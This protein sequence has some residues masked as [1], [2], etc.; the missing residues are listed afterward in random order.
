MIRIDAL[1]PL[2]VAVDG[3]LAPRELLWRKNL[4]LLLYLARSPRG[5]RPRNG[6]AS[7]FW[8][9]KPESDARHSLNEAL[10][11]IRKS[12][13]DGAL[14]ADGPTLVLDLDAVSLDADDFMDRLRA[15]DFA[16]AAAIVR[17]EFAE[18]FA[19]P[20]SN[21]FE[22]WLSA[23]RRHWR[24]LATQAL[25]SLAEE[26]L[27]NGDLVGARETARRAAALDPLAEAPATLLVHCD[28]LGGDPVAAVASYEVFAERL[29]RA[30]GL[31]PSESLQTLV[32]RI[33]TQRSI[34]DEEMRAEEPGLSRRLPL[35]GR[36]EGLK[37][38][39][40]A[41]RDCLSDR[42]P[43]L[44]IVLGGV[45]VGK[46]RLA[47]EIGARARL[48]GFRV[49]AVCC[50]AVDRDTDFG[51]LRV[52]AE[53]SELF[54][55]APA[56]SDPDAFRGA[57]R[58][59]CRSGPILVWIDDAQH[60]DAR[61]YAALG[62]LLRD[63]EG[64]PVLF[65]LC[66]TSDPPMPEVD[67]AVQRVGREVSGAVVRLEPLD[68]DALRRLAGRALPD[69]TPE[70]LDRLARRLEQDTAGIPLLAVDL[71]H[72]LR[73]GLAPTDEAAA[74]WPAP[75]RTLDDSFPGELPE[76]LLAAIRVGFRRLS[77]EAQE[78]LKV[79]AVCETRVAPEL[80]ERATDLRRASIVEALDELEWRRWL[81]A[82]PRGYSFIARL[83]RDAVAEDLMTEGQRR[84]LRTR[85]TGA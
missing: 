34:G 45:G 3:E 74:P 57:L 36:G 61:S 44:L 41:V 47:E 54:C 9:D 62:P 70:A 72:A 32:G 27:E 63:L 25:V 42:E 59:A 65:L 8:G 82:E 84:R 7:M 49:A 67:A 29:E 69:W 22:D 60:L 12:L 83:H 68:R 73:L 76:P 31:A 20:D 14:E 85:L 17:G 39:M 48:E 51:A 26:R 1:G 28:A 50:D 21:D 15:D 38:A 52:L 30:L 56:W 5:S 58:S 16:G 4:G 77:P 18:G 75:S 78:I 81:A 43:G 37:R 13:P 80:L 24:R 46:T 40:T 79:A 55:E 11:V 66:A 71:L 23:E 33:R 6:V 10:R 53:S 19:V 35:T 64:L 2:D